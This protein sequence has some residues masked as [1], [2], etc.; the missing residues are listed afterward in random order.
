[1]TGSLFSIIGIQIMFDEE[2]NQWIATH[3]QNGEVKVYDSCFSGSLSP[4]IREM[5]VRFYRPA[6]RENSLVVT[7]MPIV[8]QSGSADWSFCHWDSFPGCIWAVLWLKEL[9]QHLKENFDTGILTSFPKMT[10]GKKNSWS[11]CFFTS[12]FAGWFPK[13]AHDLEPL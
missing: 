12:C 2:R 6:V 5:L 3:Y 4:L 9:G 13:C 1:M 11:G 8:Q 10:S 7:A